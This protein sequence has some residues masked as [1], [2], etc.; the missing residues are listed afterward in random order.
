VDGVTHAEVNDSNMDE[1]VEQLLA[2]SAA[3]RDQR[4]RLRDGAKHVHSH[5]L[6]ACCLVGFYSALF[7]EI[8]AAQ[9]VQQPETP[10]AGHSSGRARTQREWLDLM[11]AYAAKRGGPRGGSEWK[12]IPHPITF[13]A[14]SGGIR[15]PLNASVLRSGGR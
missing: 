12:L 14:K 2:P 4:L 10:P 8:Y 13:A 15:R 9:Q 7:N 1:R 11:Q 5:F 3:A 6:C